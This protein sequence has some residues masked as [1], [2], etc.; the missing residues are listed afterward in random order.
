MHINHIPSNKSTKDL[1]GYLMIWI[2]AR[3]SNTVREYH[4]NTG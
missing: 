2:K 4:V 3:T 1:D